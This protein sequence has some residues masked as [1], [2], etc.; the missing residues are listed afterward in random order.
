MKKK[1]TIG[2]PINGGSVAAGSVGWAGLLGWLGW[3]RSSL[4]NSTH[5]HSLSALF[6]HS[7]KKMGKMEMIMTFLDFASTSIVDMN[8]FNEKA[9]LFRSDTGNENKHI[10]TE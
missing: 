5:L 9:S 4:G 8:I 7:E 10:I 2:L 3:F 6:L 1:K